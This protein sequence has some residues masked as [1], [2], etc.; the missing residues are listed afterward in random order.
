M[1]DNAFYLI[2]STVRK[3]IAAVHFTTT[4]CE[5]NTANRPV[6]SHITL[7]KFVPVLTALCMLSLKFLELFSTFFMS[8][9]RVFLC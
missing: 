5:P 3:K 8:V 7:V 4:P 9:Y 2:Q 6:E 1:M